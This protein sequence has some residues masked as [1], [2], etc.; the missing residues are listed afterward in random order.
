MR[1]AQGV[2]LKTGGLLFLLRKQSVRLHRFVK[3]SYR[4]DN[5]KLEFFQQWSETRLQRGKTKQLQIQRLAAKRKQG[6]LRHNGFGYEEAPATEG[7]GK[8][9]LDA[10]PLGSI[11]PGYPLNLRSSSGCVILLAPASTRARCLFLAAA[12]EVCFGLLALF[13]APLILFFFLD[14]LI[15]CNIFSPKYRCP[16]R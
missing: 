1:E 10:D 13:D 7:G 8:Q 3:L 12:R 15:C 5:N 16:R 11:T 14:L 6:N 4:Y 9:Q 2:S